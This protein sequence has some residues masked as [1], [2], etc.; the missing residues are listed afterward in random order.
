M[1]TLA[2]VEVLGRRG[3]V[4]AREKIR[5]L[6]ASIGRGFDNDVILDDEFV[7]P[8]HLQLDA[9]D[10]GHCAAPWNRGHSRAR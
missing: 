8:R 5:S 6:P 9:A 10:D 4:V 1:E 3:E 7:A 2:V